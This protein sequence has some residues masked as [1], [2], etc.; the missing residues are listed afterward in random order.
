[1]SDELEEKSSEKPQQAAPK[2]GRGR[3]RRVRLVLLPLLIAGALGAGWMWY[4]AQVRVSTDN[5]FVEG[6]VHRISPRV[7]GHVLE[8]LV[9]DNQ[10]VAAGQP[11]VRLD[12]ADFKARVDYAEARL[13]LARNETSGDYALVHEAQA[14][15]NRARAQL[16]QAHLDLA[17]GE[18]LLAKEV[19]PREQVDR[20]RTQHEVAE[21]QL[22]QAQAALARARAMVGAAPEN[23]SEA[24]IAQ[25]AAEL[26]EAR[27]N[28]S[29]TTIAA[30]VAGYVTH[31]TVE[32]GNNV[33][34][35]Q[36]LLAL[37]ELEA[38][39][40]VANYKE[41]QLT[42]IKAGQQVAF[43]VDAYPGREFAGRVDSIMAGTGAAFSL[44]PPE[45]AT[46]NYVKVVQRVPVKIAIEPGSD[47]EHLLRV[48]MSVVP[49][50]HTGR[51]LGEILAPFNPFD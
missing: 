24:R 26:E 34:A 51:S 3:P 13:A 18:A 12:P 4:D 8:V 33:Q 9:E 35:G 23:G 10:R 14:G 21:A 32:P 20:L 40:V 22:S 43:S 6:H 11:L 48:G 42:H 30:P 17:R 45:N 39:W 27:L 5:A 7:P 1:M 15:L 28:L 19:V 31:R 36:P 47:P 16:E 37:V 38:P 49:E 50:V 2:A 41:S 44:L 25:R 46:G 29:Y